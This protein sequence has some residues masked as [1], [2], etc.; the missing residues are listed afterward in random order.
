MK[1]LLEKEVTDFSEEEFTQKFGS[2]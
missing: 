1:A 2:A